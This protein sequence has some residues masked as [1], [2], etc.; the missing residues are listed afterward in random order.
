MPC[1]KL[2]ADD[3]KHRKLEEFANLN[4][5]TIDIVVKAYYHII[6]KVIGEENYG[7]TDY[8]VYY[9]A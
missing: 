6:I 4:V 1:A 5:Y 7:I 3:K 9:C 2:A 8:S